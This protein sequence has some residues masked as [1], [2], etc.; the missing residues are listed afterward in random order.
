MVISKV[1][2]NSISLSPIRWSD[3]FSEQPTSSTTI[4]TT[5]CTAK[6]QYVF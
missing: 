1:S 5:R 2:V 6:S 4:S 3:G